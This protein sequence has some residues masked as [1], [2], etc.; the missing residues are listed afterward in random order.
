MA[1]AQKTS[2]TQSTQILANPYFSGIASLFSSHGN[3]AFT[4]WSEK[5]LTY[6]FNKNTKSPDHDFAFIWNE[7]YSLAV[8]SILHNISA[9]CELEFSEVAHDADIDFWYYHSEDKVYGYSYGVGGSGVFLNAGNLINST[10]PFNGYDYLTIAHEIVHNLGLSH[11]FDGYANFPEVSS[12]LDSGRQSSN[13]NL[14]TITSYNDT[15]TTSE[16]GIEI[17][18]PYRSDQ[19]DYGLSALGVIDQAFLQ[20]LYEEQTNNQNDTLYIVDGNKVGSPWSTIWDTAGTDTIEIRS[21]SLQDAYINLQPARF[22]PNNETIHLGG[23]STILGAGYVGGYIIGENVEIENASTGLGND[24]IIGNQYSNHIT[25]EGG[26]NTVE[27]NN[28]YN[29]VEL[30]SGNDIVKLSANGIWSDA[31]FAENT[32]RLHKN[33]TSE[34]IPLHG[35]NKYTDQIFTGDGF[36]EIHLSNQNDAF[37]LDDQFSN[38]FQTKFETSKN[39]K[40]YKERI[41]DLEKIYAGNGDDLLDMTSVA[42][43]ASNM[44]LVGGNGNDII[45]AG[46]GDDILIGGSGNDQ[47]NGGAGDDHLNGG[48]GENTF[49][50]AG[51]F[52]NDLIHD[53]NDG[54]NLLKFYNLE[55][56]N[57]IVFENTIN[58][59]SFGTIT[60]KDMDFDLVAQIKIEKA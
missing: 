11:P 30:G 56:V 10:I 6:K 58:F 57:P 14:Y 15:G 34:K 54:I 59:D 4:L 26:N 35:L 36:D 48:I 19:L 49:S 27:T 9:I 25:S 22:Q 16:E 41:T 42:I 38:V 46:A 44:E 51:N 3:P 33:S 5:N 55:Q 50:F 12:P 31:Y 13:Q 2:D 39:D 32:A 37:F 24:I 53:W 43:E 28:G 7:N 60:F 45:W 29:L 52:G 1:V 40:G 47:L 18:P 17:N 21:T 8:E 20:L 23:I